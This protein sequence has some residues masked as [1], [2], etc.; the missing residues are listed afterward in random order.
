MWKNREKR[1]K[2]KQNKGKGGGNKGGML[3]LIIIVGGKEGDKK[4]DGGDKVV[5]NGIEKWDVKELI[6]L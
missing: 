2:K 6:I 1:N 3:Q 5:G 4:G